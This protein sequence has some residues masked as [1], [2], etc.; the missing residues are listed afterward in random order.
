VIPKPS[1]SFLHRSAGLLS[2]AHPRSGGVERGARLLGGWSLY[3]RSPEFSS[4]SSPTAP[5]ISQPRVSSLF[6]ISGK[7]G[8]SGVFSAGLGRRKGGGISDSPGAAC[9][10]RVAGVPGNAGSG[11][12]P[13]SS[14][15]MVVEFFILSL[16]CD[17][18]GRWAF[19]VFDSSGQ[20]CK[21]MAYA[22]SPRFGVASQWERWIS[23]KF[24]QRRRWSG[25]PLK[26]CSLGEYVDYDVIFTSFRGLLEKSQGCVCKFTMLS[27]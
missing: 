3:R 25:V 14:Q 1:L 21:M 2:S 9:S 24:G 4:Y 23:L 5:S 16:L 12:Q 19:S 10:Y 22:A 13:S 15:M 18:D 7:G 11:F 26:L 6:L 8:G 17:G 20:V 27:S